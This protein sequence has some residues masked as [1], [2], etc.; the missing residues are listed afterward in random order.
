MLARATEKLTF[1]TVQKLERRQYWALAL[2]LFLM[3]LSVVWLSFQFAPRQDGPALFSN[4]MYTLTSLVGAAWC[5]YAVYQ[6]THGPVVLEKRHRLAW[7]FIGLG[8]LSNGLGNIYYGSYQYLLRTEPPTPS[9]ADIGFTLFYVF[10]L[11]G[12]VILP[13]NNRGKRPGLH[14]LIDSLVTVLCLLGISWFILINPILIQ[15]EPDQFLA[16]MMSV[17][18]PCWDILLLIALI[19]F[20][21][22]RALP[23]L[24]PSLWICSLG[25]L[26]QVWA[27]GSYAYLVNYNLYHS[28]LVMVDPFWFL[29]YLLIGIA[30]LYQYHAIV[31]QTFKNSQLEQKN[32]SKPA[33]LVRN[34]LAFEG[35]FVLLKVLIL[36]IP[37]LALL[38]VTLY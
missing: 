34:D 6:A 4:V 8:L 5:L 17:S 23:V 33:P 27:D 15:A 19:L 10:C 35:R 29:G 18:Y 2:L 3:I 12:L 16:T 9:Y 11:A 13:T 26:A 37:F 1:A 14:V 28:G 30:P 20:I 24:R 7:I 25:V 32:T 36:Y 21:Y 31:R 22:Q 38:L